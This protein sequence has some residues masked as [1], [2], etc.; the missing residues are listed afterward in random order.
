MDVPGVLEREDDPVT[1]PGGG[2]YG[3]QRSTVAVEL[4][5][6]DANVAAAGGDH[7]DLRI[8]WKVED[9]LRVDHGELG[10]FRRPDDRVA[11]A[12]RRRQPAWL[13]RAVRGDH[14]DVADELLPPLHLELEA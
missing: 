2:A 7:A 10:A 5:R 13:I 3:R 11:G 14:V 1:V 8:A 12:L 4:R 6:Q 9:A